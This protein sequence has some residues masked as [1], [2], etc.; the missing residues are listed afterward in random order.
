VREAVME[1]MKKTAMTA[2][3]DV[4]VQLTDGEYSLVRDGVRLAERPFDGALYE[5]YVARLDGVSWPD[6]G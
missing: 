4:L 2:I 6:E 3:H 5:D 1:V